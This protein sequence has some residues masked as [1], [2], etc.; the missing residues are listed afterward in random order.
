MILVSKLPSGY[1]NREEYNKYMREYRRKIRKQKKF[2]QLTQEEKRANAK[3]YS[4]IITSD[5]LLLVAEKEAVIKILNNNSVS[6]A[7][8]LQRIKNVICDV[9]RNE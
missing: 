4:E 2:E 3:K 5:Y 7:E 6:D 1:K 9:K 8:K